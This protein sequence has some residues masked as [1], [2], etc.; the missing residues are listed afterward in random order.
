[1]DRARAV[2][3]NAQAKRRLFDHG[4]PRNRTEEDKGQSTWMRGMDSIMKR[5][6]RKI[7]FVYFVTFVAPLFFWL[8]R[9]QNTQKERVFQFCIHCDTHLAHLGMLNAFFSVYFREFRG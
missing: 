3:A 9:A 5:A 4:M 1:L 2:H 6:V 8:Q 7:P